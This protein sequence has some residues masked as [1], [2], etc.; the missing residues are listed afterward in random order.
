MA[1]E[2]VV[3]RAEPTRGPSLVIPRRALLRAG[4]QP[5][6][7]PPWRP[8]TPI[9]RRLA[10]TGSA[11][12]ALPLA[13]PPAFVMSQE[14]IG[15]L[16]D[17]YENREVIQ[18][19]SGKD[20][21]F[22][23]GLSQVGKSTTICAWLGAEFKWVREYA[24]P[25]VLE[26]T[27]SPPG[28]L[29]AMGRG[30]ST[31][32]FPASYLLP[33]GLVALDSR[34]HGDIRGLKGE[35]TAAALVLEYAAR[36]AKSLRLVVMCTTNDLSQ[37]AAFSK[38]GK[39]FRGC[40][41]SA[42]VP[43]FVLCRGDLSGRPDE[44]RGWGLSKQQQYALH[45]IRDRFEEMIE[46]TKK[47]VEKDVRRLSGRSPWVA[48]ALSAW[49]REQAGELD[50]AVAVADVEVDELERFRKNYSWIPF[51]KAVLKEERYA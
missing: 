10:P 38:L 39:L 50:N 3:T 4:Q 37:A 26:M 48:N 29:P 17:V 21:L 2:V 46:Q 18:T 30:V 24:K 34:G 9:Q 8:C 35:E 42:D 14:M 36:A 7:N 31:T 27:K 44:A 49:L 43:V 20:L 12:A 40:L 47:K 25:P 22:L 51:V 5:A 19:A 41:R 11:A 13:G 28:A 15:V 6:L 1:D 23:V 16:D 45:W 32:D 33:Q